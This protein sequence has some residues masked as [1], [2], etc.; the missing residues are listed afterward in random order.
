[1]IDRITSLE[2][3][4]MQFHR[5]FQRAGCEEIAAAGF[6]GLLING[7][8]GV[9]C[10]IMPEAMVHT[11][12]IDNFMP[13]TIEMNRREIARRVAIAKS[14][15]LEPWLLMNGVPGPDEARGG[16]AAEMSNL[17]DRMFKYE[18]HAALEREP[19]VFGRTGWT[20]RGNRPLCV[21]NPKVKEFYRQLLP[22]ILKET[23][24]I[25]GALYFPGD[26]EP[27][28]CNHRCEAC[29]ETGKTPQQL[30]IEHVNELYASVT[31]V[32]PDFRLYVAIWNHHLPGMEESARYLI[33]NLAPGI[34]MCL[35]MADHVVECRRIGEFKFNQP[36]SICP[37]IGKEFTERAELSRK[38]SRKLMI[39]GEWAQSEV[40]D[41]VCHNMPNP[42]KTI[43]F[44]RNAE[45][46]EGCDVIFDF[47]GHRGPYRGHMNFEAMRAYTDAPAKSTDELLR[48]AVKSY[49]AIDDNDGAMLDEAVATVKR[50]E[51]NCD[52]WALGYWC[53]RFS[54]SAGRDAARGALFRPF[55]PPFL[56]NVKRGWAWSLT[57]TNGIDVELMIREQ[58]KDRDYFVETSQRFRELSAKLAEQG[59]KIGSERARLDGLNIALAGEMIACN[60]RI[61]RAADE[62]EK[63]DVEALR[64]TIE[65]EIE[66]RIRLLELT[67]EVGYA[68]AAGVN[69]LL[70]KEDIQNM[71][72]YLS[73]PDFPDTADEK[74]RFTHCPYAI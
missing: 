29:K 71:M 12:V 18:M 13:H 5:D 35:V 33:E 7:G 34:G 57:R 30:M 62:W 38:Y 24:E 58:L 25:K 44:L 69:P 32:R 4:G 73:A 10:D 15:G 2:R 60:A 66:N 56:R 59:N 68:D 36:W 39:M 49:Y 26:N 23:P 19:E 16:D 52:E 6:T 3:M 55:V 28:Q 17:N 51:K 37:H 20:W 42:E 9:A 50:F 53:H 11:D 45:S 43:T 65:D 48:L 27:E 1:M 74:F 14:C 54:F 64:K 70:V 31:A 22:N 21:S 40:W 63:H 72:Y 46:I 41:P 67:G 8:A 47:W 61:L